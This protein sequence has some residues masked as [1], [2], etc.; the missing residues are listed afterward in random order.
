MSLPLPVKIL[1]PYTYRNWVLQQA[2][3][4]VGRLADEIWVNFEFFKFI[5]D[6]YFNFLAVFNKVTALLK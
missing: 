6:K 1:E 5:I 2:G 3:W 4:K